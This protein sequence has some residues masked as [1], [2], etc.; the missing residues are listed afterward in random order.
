MSESQR[1][2]DAGMAPAQHQGELDDAA[3]ERMRQFIL[4]TLDKPEQMAQWFGRVMTQ[5]KYVDQLMPLD[6]PLDEAALVAQ[7][8]QGEP[9]F[10]MPGSRFARRSDA[11]GTTL[12]VDGDGH[13]CSEALAKRVADPEPM[14]DEVLELDGAA[15]LLTQLINSGSLGFMGEDDE[16]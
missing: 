14:Y 10:H 16:E 3:I 13:A 5:P 11:A 4:S 2:S 8:Q 15:A 12:F 1:Y 7:L 9:L 6:E